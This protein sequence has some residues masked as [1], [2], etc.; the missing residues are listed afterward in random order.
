M[1]KS[2]ARIIPI[3]ISVALMLAGC[4][5]IKK[6][7]PVRIKPLPL[8]VYKNKAIAYEKNRNLIKALEYW[9][10]TA[11]IDPFDT[12]S[13]GKVA[14]LKAVCQSTAKKHFE[15]GVV[16][17]RRRQLKNAKKEF[18]IALRH[19]PEHQQSMNYLKNKFSRSVYT[20]YQVKQGDTYNRIA[21]KVYKDSGKGFLIAS[22]NKHAQ[23][24]PQPGTILKIPRLDNIEKATQKSKK[25]LPDKPDP[26][27]DVDIEESDLPAQTISLNPIIDI[28]NELTNARN[29]STAKNYPKVLPIT[30]TILENDP[31]NSEALKLKNMAYLSMGKDLAL[32]KK[33]TESLN[34]LNEADAD[35]K[36]AQEAIKD[37]R[38]QMLQEAEEHYRKGVG[39]YREEELS[40]AI[41]EWEQTLLLNPEHSKARKDIETARNLLEK[42]KKIQ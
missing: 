32:K 18:L 28:E 34:M 42:L 5:E 3:L 40:K 6:P 33:F 13:K 29:Y 2:I 22:I 36:G 11:S 35:F 39:L 14:I 26:E 24:K 31:R 15:K 1:K 20:T 12:K 38:K 8:S 16:Y 7:K 23:K 19:N 10:I 37:V 17:Y 30:Q 4:A 25:E 27:P 41:E 9:K 21:G